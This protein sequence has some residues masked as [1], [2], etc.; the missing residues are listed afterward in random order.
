MED[1]IKHAQLSGIPL[2]EEL[3]SYN[4]ARDKL[5]QLNE[6]IEGLQAQVEVTQGEISALKEKRLKSLSAGRDPIGIQ[7]QIDDKQAEI[8]KFEGWIG[9]LNQLIAEAEAKLKDTESTLANFIGKEL[10]RCSAEVNRQFEE[11]VQ[12]RRAIGDVTTDGVIDTQLPW[13]NSASRV[14]V[15]EICRQDI[16]ILN[17]EKVGLPITGGMFDSIIAGG[18][19]PFPT[20]EEGLKEVEIQHF[21]CQYCNNLPWMEKN[22][23]LTNAGFYVVEAEEPESEESE[24]A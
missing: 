4:G 12:Q 11:V 20:V 1:K 16:A 3:E 6:R 13:E 5:S 22:K 14:C 15:C 9:D 8:L 21:H 18:N 17:H 2:G 23:V 10:L 19:A 7:K 24:A